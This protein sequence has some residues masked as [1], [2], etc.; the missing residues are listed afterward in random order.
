MEKEEYVKEFI[1]TINSQDEENIYHFFTRNSSIALL[2]KN[3]EVDLP[4]LVSYLKENYFGKEIV[5]VRELKSKVCNKLETKVD[6]KDVSFY[7][8]IK[9]RRIGR[10]EILD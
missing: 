9:D 7:F 4:S 6:S 3:K 2:S 10:L 1:K 5:I 8:E